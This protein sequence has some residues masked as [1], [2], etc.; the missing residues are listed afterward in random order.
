[1]VYFGIWDRCI[2]RFVQQV[3]IDAKNDLETNANMDYA[4]WIPFGLQT[5]H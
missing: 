4:Y 1:M 2:V 3:Y 5:D